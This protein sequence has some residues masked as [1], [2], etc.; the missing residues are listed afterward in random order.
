MSPL[1]DVSTS[2]PADPAAR[3]AKWNAQRLE[4]ALRAYRCFIYQLGEDT[5]ARLAQG[6]AAG[7][8]Y[9]VVFGKTQSARPR[10]CS[11]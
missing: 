9:V 11:I 3:W 10:C 5:R 1:G 2:A 8:A 7:E 4:W 6:D